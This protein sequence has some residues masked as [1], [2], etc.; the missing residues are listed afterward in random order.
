V[1]GIRFY[2]LPIGPHIRATPAARLA[3]EPWPKIG[4]SDIIGPSI[5]ADRR[6]MAAMIVGT[7]DEQTA[8]ALR[9]PYF[10]GCK[11]GELA[12]SSS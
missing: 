2:T 6:P 1:S 4:Q 5:A 3:G 7:I 11:P 9:R 8:P 10:G 12:Q